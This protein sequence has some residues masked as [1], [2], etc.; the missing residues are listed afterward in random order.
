MV[1]RKCDICGKFYENYENGNEA[2]EISEIRFEPI[3]F[4]CYRN[5]VKTYYDTCPVCL[6]RIRG[7]IAH[8]G[9]ES[10]TKECN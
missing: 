7:F 10:E 8:L 3:T 2:I 9:E 6:M 4:T 5:V 1:V